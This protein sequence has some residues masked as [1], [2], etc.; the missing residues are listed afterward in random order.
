MEKEGKILR[1]KNTE[2]LIDDVLYCPHCR[3]NKKT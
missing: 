1:N 2:D 3:E